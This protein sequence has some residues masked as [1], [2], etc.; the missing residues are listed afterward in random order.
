[1]TNSA[2]VSLLIRLLTS[3]GF[4]YRDP[5]PGTPGYEVVNAIFQQK[6]TA[7][8]ALAY[9]FDHLIA[10]R[11]LSG[12]CFNWSLALAYLLR[13]MGE[14]VCIV[15]TPEG[16]GSK[17]SLAYKSHGELIAAD[18]VEYIKGT[19]SVDEISAI[20]FEQFIKPFEHHVLL[21]PDKIEGPLMDSMLGND[22]RSNTTPAEFLRK[23]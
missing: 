5:Q 4:D 9:V 11:E 14:K 7:D 2:L 15:L 1:M 3:F 13:L 12:C 16:N 18:I 20:P 23:E 6:M 22:V 19:S 21:D 8:Q 17:V 10:K